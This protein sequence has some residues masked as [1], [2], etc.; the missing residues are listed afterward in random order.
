MTTVPWPV[1]K[2]FLWYMLGGVVLYFFY[3]IRNSN[4]QRGVGVTVAPTWARC[5][6]GGQ[7]IS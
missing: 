4:L 5:R 3:G 1:L 2:F 6:P 7:P